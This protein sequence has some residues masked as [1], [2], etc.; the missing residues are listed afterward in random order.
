MTDQHYFRT[1]F[2]QWHG[3]WKDER[4]LAVRTNL[5]HELAQKYNTSF[6]EG[7]FGWFHTGAGMEETQCFN[8]SYRYVQFQSDC[9]TGRTFCFAEMCGFLPYHTKEFPFSNLEIA[10][11]ILLSNMHNGVS[12]SGLHGADILQRDRLAS[13]GSYDQVYSWADRYMGLHASP[14]LSPGAW[15]AMRGQG[16]DHPPHGDYDFL[17]NRVGGDSSEGQQRCGGNSSNVWNKVPYSAWCR[18]L[19]EGGEMKFKVKDGLFRRNAKNCVQ[20]RVVFLMHQKSQG[21]LS[22]W[23]DDGSPTGSQALFAPG[24]GGTSWV[25]ATSTVANATFSGEGQAD[26]W[27]RHFNPAKSAP[28]AMVHM[29]EVRKASDCVPWRGTVII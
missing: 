22:L 12:A 2:E 23:Y 19:P 7:H 18:S 11:W 15:V 21:G 16:D 3:L 20:V 4:K 14:S 24:A 28:P 9:K 10:Y 13:N 1:M 27:L 6:Q 25:D 29:V 26:L 8:Q 5:V 17:M